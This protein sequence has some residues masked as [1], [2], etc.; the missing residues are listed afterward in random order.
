MPQLPVFLTVVSAGNFNI[1]TQD[2]LLAGAYN[3]EVR[4]TEPTFNIKYIA[5]TFVVTILEPII[6][7]DLVPALPLEPVRYLVGNPLLNFALPEY[8][9]VPA[10]ANKAYVFTPGTFPPFVTYLPG[11]PG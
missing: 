6:A 4:A 7:T 2:S 1:A 3:F 8:V 5:N 9:T 10:D 11:S